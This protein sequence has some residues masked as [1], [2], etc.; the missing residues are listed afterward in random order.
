[1]DTFL[2]GAVVL[3]LGMLAIGINLL[4][5]WDP[6]SR[7]VGIA[8]LLGVGLSIYLLI[9]HSLPV[10]ENTPFGMITLGLL[11]VTGY[12][13]G[14]A[15]VS[16]IREDWLDNLIE[17]KPSELSAVEPQLTTLSKPG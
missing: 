13:G 17:T 2:V 3:I 4:T 8:S 10:K 6:E 9:F 16:V 7:I 14:R 1:M 11:S 5:K 15:F 12:L